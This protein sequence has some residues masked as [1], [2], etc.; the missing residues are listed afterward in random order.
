MRY[1]LV[2]LLSVLVLSSAGAH[3]SPA[4]STNTFAYYETHPCSIG[5]VNFDF[6]AAGAYTFTADDYNPGAADVTVT[7]VGTGL[8]AGQQVGFM[9]VNNNFVV[10]A[11]GGTLLYNQNTDPFGGSPTCCVAGSGANP[12]GTGWVATNPDTSGT[13]SIAELNITFGV[14]INAPGNALNS[15]TTQLGVFIYSPD[16]G[17]TSVQAGALTVDHTGTPSSSTSFPQPTT[18]FT[19][20]QDISMKATFANTTPNS[21]ALNS[22]TETFTFGDTS[23]PEP[24]S[25]LMIGMAALTFAAFRWRKCLNV[26][27]ARGTHR[28]MSGPCR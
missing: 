17:G 23:V 18:S 10:G 20:N 26:F 3:A 24:G 27:F 2:L 16:G 13:F 7:P 21:A 28:P 25:F 5:L 6:S 12:S 15:T 1:R 19:V 11:P 14:S 8:V 4:C 22:L 9:F